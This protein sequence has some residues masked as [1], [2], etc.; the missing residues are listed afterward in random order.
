MHQYSLPLSVLITSFYS[1][2]KSL[3]HTHTHT[4]KQGSLRGRAGLMEA[5]WT[6]TDTHARSD[7]ATLRLLPGC[8]HVYHATAQAPP[9]VI[10][11][12]ENCLDVTRPSLCFPC[13]R[14]EP[15]WSGAFSAQTLSIHRLCRH[16][17]LTTRRTGH[18]WD[19]EGTRR[20][21]H[22]MLVSDDAD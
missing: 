17:L 16:S 14:R 1:F 13:T 2:S 11:K 9:P 6:H 19:E 22:H 20:T 12:P 10:F 5:Y 18:V 7:A 8:A 21:A 4:G 15:I 3:F